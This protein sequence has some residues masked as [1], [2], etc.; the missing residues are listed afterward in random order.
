MYVISV[1]LGKDK[2]IF[3][4]QIQNCNFVFLAIFLSTGV[5]YVMDMGV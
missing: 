3:F 4:L 5:M 1:E 2:V